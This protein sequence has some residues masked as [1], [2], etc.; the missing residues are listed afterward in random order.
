MEVGIAL[1]QMA[2]GLD[3][4]LVKA[5]CEAIDA[6]PFSSVS[7]GERMTFHNL[8]GVTLCT[9]AA[10]FTERVKVL[11]NVV[12]LP[13]HAPTLI[14]KQI[15]S[16]DVLSAGRVEVAVGVGGRQQDYDALGASFAGR[17]RRLDEGVA[18][19]RRIWGG[20]LMGDGQPVG[21]APVQP[22]GPPVYASAMGPKSLAR[23]AQ[24]ADGISG[25]TLLGDAAEVARGFEA[26]QHAWAEADRSTSPRLVTG[27]FVCLGADA[28]VTLQSFAYRYLEVFSPQLAKGLS[29]AMPLHTPTRSSRCCGRSR[30]PAA[31]S[32]SSSPPPPIPTASPTSP[33]SSPNSAADRAVPARPFTHRSVEVS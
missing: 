9:A 22:G 28:Q 11:F 27:S 20:G 23:A 10:A 29:E 30:T 18:E 26:A 3:R 24:W 25:F 19:L 6:G 8:E 32:S 5:W 15:A 21:P 7:A 1:P 33:R 16:M 31:T 14:A 12:V 17:H 13:W 4:G 2:A